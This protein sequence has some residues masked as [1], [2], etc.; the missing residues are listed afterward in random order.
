MTESMGNTSFRPTRAEDVDFVLGVE[1]DPKTSPFIAHWSREEHQAAID[2]DDD[3]HWILE[4]GGEAVGYLILQSVHSDRV[5][6]RRIAI[7]RKGKG[8]GRF[9][10][11]E[12]RRVVFQEWGATVLWLDV[13]DFNTRA[14]ELY[15]AEGWVTVGTRP[16]VE[17]CGVEEGTAL[18]M[19]LRR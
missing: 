11:R 13:F 10:L 17:A 3:A 12:T 8:Y 16:A 15:Q 14:I 19:E 9:A 1:A 18:L 5:E 6:L 2:S 4:S 7:A